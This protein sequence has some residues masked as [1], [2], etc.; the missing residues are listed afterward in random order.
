MIQTAETES[1]AAMGETVSDASAVRRR[2]VEKATDAVDRAQ[3][4][5][6]AA[7]AEIGQA[8]QSAAGPALEDA[9]AARRQ[10]THGLGDIGRVFAE[11]AD[12]QSRHGLETFRALVSTVD[13]GQAATIQGDFVRTTVERMLE[14]CRRYMGIMLATHAALASVAGGSAGKPPSGS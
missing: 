12:E 2:T 10:S 13:W 1:E 7:N 11:L 8:T 14:L 6:G 9:R 3:E 5:V 4:R